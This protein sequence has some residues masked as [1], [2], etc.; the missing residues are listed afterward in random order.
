MSLLAVGWFYGFDVF[1]FFFQGLIYFQR[2]PLWIVRSIYNFFFCF[3]QILLFKKQFSS[4]ILFFI[5]LRE[6]SGMI[7]VAGFGQ[8]KLKKNIKRRYNVA[9][10][11]KLCVRV[12]LC[13]ANAAFFLGLLLAAPV[14]SF[15]ARY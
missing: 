3:A 14:L 5:F 7:C 6:G 2:E 11:K 8:T 13:P 4:R 10:K 9:R 15:G 12:L 1:F